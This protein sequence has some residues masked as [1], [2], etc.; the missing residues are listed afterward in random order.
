[1]LCT[2]GAVLATWAAVAI[3]Q[4]IRLAAAGAVGIPAGG[5]ALSAGP[6]R[7][8]AVQW[9]EWS[10]V[11][12]LA[13]AAVVLSGSLLLVPAAA[14]LDGLVRLVRAPGLLRG[15]SLELVLVALAWWPA[16]LFAAAFASSGGPVGE[17][18]QRI[19]G[20]KAGR[21]ATLGL[22]V[23]V[24]VL[25]AGPAA[26]RAV[27]VAGAWMRTDGRGFRQRLVRTVAGYPVALALLGLTLQ[28]NWLPAAAA[29]A[30]AGAWVAALQFRTK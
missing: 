7:L 9:G 21:W 2:I 8:P 15:L 23:L 4:A 6:A 18:Y 3:D 24:L 30:W 16:A 25:V 14:A 22:G 29:V 10:A 28:G 5:L 1:M 11:A 19:G 17:L 12:P 27:A 26:G 20:P 13:A